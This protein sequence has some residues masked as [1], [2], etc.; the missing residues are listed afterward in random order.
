MRLTVRDN[1]VVESIPVCYIGEATLYNGIVTVRTPYLRRDSRI[2]ATAAETSGTVGILS[3]PR[4]Y[5]DLAAGTFRIES[6]ST[7]GGIATLDNSV[8]EWVLVNP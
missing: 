4:Q 5:R 1:R 8:V 3:V 6:I 2:V 7:L